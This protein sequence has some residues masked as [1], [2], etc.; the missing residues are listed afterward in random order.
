MQPANKKK[1]QEKI[2][3]LALEY[4]ERSVK[5]APDK[6]IT[7][8]RRAIANGRIAL[9]KGVFSVSGVVNSVKED[10][11]KAISLNNSGPIALAPSYYVLSRTHSKTSE[12]SK[13]FRM[14]LGLGWAD[15]DKAIEYFEKA[16]KLRPDFR[17]YRLDYAKALIKKEDNKKAIEQLEAI[18]NIPKYDE[19]DDEFLKEAEKL[20]KEL[21][22]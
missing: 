2:Y 5:I 6:T 12:K 10:L 7:L 13:L 8:L 14:S 20:I 19:D 21:K 17:M 4:A 1:E 18:K 9:Y 3:N 15:L 22:K 16:I 11:E